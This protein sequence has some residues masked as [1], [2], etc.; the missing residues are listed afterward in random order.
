MTKNRSKLRS[1]ENSCLLSAMQLSSLGLGF[2]GDPIDAARM[3][4]MAFQQSPYAQID[5]AAGTMGSD[6]VVHVAG[7]GGVKAAS[8]GQQGGNQEL[9]ASEEDKE[10]RANRANRRATS[11][12]SCSGL[13]ASAARRGFT[14]MLQCG[15]S[16]AY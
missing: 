13:A 12:C 6:C 8:G 4:G 5:A 16:E 1:I 2:L 9:V 11:C 15:P 14:T 3:P 7:A 10:C